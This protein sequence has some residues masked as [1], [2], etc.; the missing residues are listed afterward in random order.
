VAE[1]LKLSAFYIAIA[2]AFGGYIWWAWSNGTLVTSDGTNPV[3]SYFQGYI[4]EKVLSIDNVF[5]IS[6][7]FGYFAIPRKYQYRALVWGII[8]VIILRGIMIAIGAELIS[9]LRLG[10]AGLRRVPCLHR[11]QDAGGSGR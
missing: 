2:I 11:H 1:S 4:I 6:L 3:A 5:V 10:H 9:N 8:G 7:I